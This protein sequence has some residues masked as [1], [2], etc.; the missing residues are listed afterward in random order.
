MKKFV[1]K[2]RNGQVYFVEWDSNASSDENDDDEDN[3]PS[4]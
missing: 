2:K 4:K 3:K 1:K